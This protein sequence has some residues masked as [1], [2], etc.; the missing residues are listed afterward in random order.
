[1]VNKIAE[2]I[3]SN[4][5]QKN[6]EITVDEKIC[7]NRDCINDAIGN[8]KL[9]EK[10]RIEVSNLFMDTCYDIEQKGFTDGFAAGIKFVM[11]AMAKE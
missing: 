6:P 8:E 5:L 9:S 10:E 3:F 2:M 7:T 1:M 4:N 11:Q